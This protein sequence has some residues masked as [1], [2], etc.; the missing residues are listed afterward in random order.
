MEPAVSLE[1][2][3]VSVVDV[4]CRTDFV[5]VGDFGKAVY[6]HL[7]CMHSLSIVFGTCMGC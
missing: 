2:F 5:K 6:A 4:V 1:S 3:G 7:Q